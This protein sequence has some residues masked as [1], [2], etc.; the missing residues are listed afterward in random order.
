V[1]NLTLEAADLIM[2]MIVAEDQIFKNT[3]SNNSGEVYLNRN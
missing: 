3:V 1:Y 2:G